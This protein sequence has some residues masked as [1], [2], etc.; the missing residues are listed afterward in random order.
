MSS[1]EITFIAALVAALS[2]LTWLLTGAAICWL[3]AAAGAACAIWSRS[4]KRKR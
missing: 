2:I 3:F 4:N 1:T